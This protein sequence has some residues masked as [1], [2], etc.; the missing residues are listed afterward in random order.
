MLLELS[1]IMMDIGI[2]SCSATVPDTIIVF[3]SEYVVLSVVTVI[4]AEV[5]AVAERNE[6]V[7]SVIAT[8]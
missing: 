5:C 6:I 3:P 2:L 7:K 8:R 1:L 4:G